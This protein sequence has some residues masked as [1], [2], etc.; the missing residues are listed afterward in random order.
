M[1]KLFKGLDE[2]SNLS[3]KEMKSRFLTYEAEKNK[4]DDDLQSQMAEMIA[5]L[6]S[7]SG[8]TSSGVAIPGESYKQVT[9]DYPKNT[10]HMPHINHSVNVPHFDGTHFSFWKS[11]MEPHIR[12]CSVEM[13]EII[14]DGY[15]KPQDP[16]RLTSTKFYNRQLSASACDKVRSGINR[17]LLDQV[18]DI[19]SAEELC[20]RIVVLQEG[21]NL[22]QKSLYELAK[23]EATLFMIKEGETIVEACGRLGALRVKVKGLCCDKYNDGFEVNEEF[24]K[25]KVIDMIAI[26]QKDTN[27]ALNLRILTK[28]AD[29]STDNLVSYMVAMTTWPKKEKDS[30]TDQ[31]REE[32]YEIEEE[33][34]MTSTSDIGTNFAF[35]VKKYK[36]KFPI[37]SNEKK[38]TCYNCDEDNHFANE[39]PYEK[40][41]D[42]PRFV[43]EAEDEEKEAGVAGLAFSKDYSTESSTP[44]VIGS[45]F[46]ARMTYDDDSDDSSSSTVVGSCLM[47]REAKWRAIRQENPYHFEARTYTGPDKLFWTKTQAKLWDDFYDDSDHMKKGF[48]VLP[49]YLNMDHF[50]LCTTTDFRFIDDALER[51]NVLD[52]V[53]IEKDLLLLPDV[54][55]Q[56]HAT[57]FFHS[58]AACT[59][60]WMTGRDQY[61]ASFEDFCDA[62]GYGGGWASGFKVHSQKPMPIDKIAFCYTPDPDQIPPR[63]T[64]MYYYYHHTLAKIFRE[65]L[66][67]KV[68]DKASCHHYYVNLMY[69]CRV[70]NLNKINGCDFIFCELQRS[71]EKRMPPNY[72]Q[73]VQCLLSHVVPADKLPRGQQVRMESFSLALRGPYM[74]VPEMMS[75]KGAAKFFTNLWQMCKCSYDLNHRALEMAQETRRRQDEFVSAQNVTVPQPGPEMNPVPYDSFV[76]PTIDDAMFHGFDMSR[77]PPFVSG[78]APSRPRRSVPSGS[79]TGSGSHTGSGDGEEE[80]EESSQHPDDSAFFA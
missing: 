64:G 24:I 30:W 22:F 40:R 44:N 38:R 25:S 51:L 36:K 41:V 49:K 61:Y 8:G 29:L 4:K 21:T 74:D 10:S 6:K 15:R 34:E 76:M 50:S 35:F 68:G 69:Y 16:I 42:K 79:G 55:R 53:L 14:I 80:S 71:V 65:N 73:F 7:L 20:D 1:D 26:K 31:E 78:R 70:E 75:L 32:V 13:W 72:C 48:Y 47:A 18:N 60:T 63:I 43:K 59:I 11:S 66:V 5:M 58:A 17:K 23:T 37:S 39:C 27:L 3:V 2:D 28:Q 12:S 54:I 52:L 67:S 77:L 57:V 62:L 19:V 9:H 45:S 33:E 56:F 46:M